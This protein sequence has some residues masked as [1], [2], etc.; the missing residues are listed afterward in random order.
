MLG[1]LIVTVAVITSNYLA[2]SYA[3]Y[4]LRFD[5]EP[6]SENKFVGSLFRAFCPDATIADFYAAAIALG[7]AIGFF[8]IFKESFGCFDSWLSMRLHNADGN[9]EQTQAFKW[10]LVEKGLSLVLLVVSIGFVTAWD[11][12]LFRY[13][14]AAQIAGLDDP[15]KAVQLIPWREQLAQPSLALDVTS[16]GCWGYLALTAATCLCTELTARKS[17]RYAERLLAEID[18]IPAANAQ[19]LAEERVLKGY[20][21]DGQPV[22]DAAT[23]LAYDAEGNT[24]GLSDPARATD[25]GAEHARTEQHE[26][27]DGSGQAPLFV[28]PPMG[29]TESTEARP[30]APR[31]TAEPA[32][33]A[34]RQ[35]DAA[36]YTV[37]G[38]GEQVSWTTAAQDDKRYYCDMNHVVWDRATYDAIHDHGTSHDFE[39][40]PQAA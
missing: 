13:R 15:D 40:A 18:G 24:L 22:Y 29:R 9:T 28:V 34:A 35:A 12:Q 1:M 26:E 8:L 31:P 17:R 38:T 2:I 21:A 11:M 32:Q 27:Q 4:L 16:I 33:E 19:V 3:F 23:P 14:A 37:V 36:V 20:D 25:A 30:A 6:I 7:L 39:P 5:A 10:D